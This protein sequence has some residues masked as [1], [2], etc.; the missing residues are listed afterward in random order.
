[1][2]DFDRKLVFTS[3]N[4]LEPA[5]ADFGEIKPAESCKEGR[6]ERLRLP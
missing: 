4:D 3:L 6:F 1:M 5:G 2:P